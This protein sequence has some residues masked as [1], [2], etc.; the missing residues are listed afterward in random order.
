MSYANMTLYTM[1][2]IH[3]IVVSHVTVTHT[4]THVFLVTVCLFMQ[5]PSFPSLFC[6]SGGQ[7][8]IVTGS[9]FPCG[10]LSIVTQTL[11]KDAVM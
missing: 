10:N 5:P 3:Y 11:N 2:L 4:H 6:A 7:A 1:I 8:V 9:R